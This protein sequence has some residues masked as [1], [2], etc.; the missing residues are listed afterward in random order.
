MRGYTPPYTPSRLTAVP[1]RMGDDA[2]RVDWVVRTWR[3]R[4]L[5]YEAPKA[6][7]IA[8]INEIGRDRIDAAMKAAK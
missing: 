1:R 8:Y 7:A 2:A 3:K 5:I 6:A 4:G